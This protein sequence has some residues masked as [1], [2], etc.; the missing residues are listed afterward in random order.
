M[1]K[2]IRLQFSCSIYVKKKV[3]NREKSDEIENKNADL[4]V[5]NTCAVRQHAE[6]RAFGQLGNLKKISL[7]RLKMMSTC[8]IK[9]IQLMP[10]LQEEWGHI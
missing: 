6:E 5:I 1:I 10:H 8:I 7:V 2:H 4:V 9:W 3:G